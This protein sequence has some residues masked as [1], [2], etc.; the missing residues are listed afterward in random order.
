M[1]IYAW[2]SGRYVDIL[3]T[4]G[5]FVDV[6]ALW[7]FQNWSWKSNTTWDPVLAGTRA[8]PSDAGADALRA[9]QALSPLLTS[10]PSSL[11]APLLPPAYYERRV[12]EVVPEPQQM[13]GRG[14]ELRV[15][16]GRVGAR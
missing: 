14:G 5:R 6:D 11:D 12:L 7:T 2:T 9:I 16:A 8:V 4:C 13:P 3:W 1:F 10:L 15:G